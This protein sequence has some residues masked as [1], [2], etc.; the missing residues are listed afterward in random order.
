MPVQNIYIQLAALLYGV[1]S[2]MADAFPILKNGSNVPA[3]HGHEMYLQCFS[4]GAPLLETSVRLLP[5]AL[6]HASAS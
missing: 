5:T 2:C 4:G 3:L 6:C 1:Q